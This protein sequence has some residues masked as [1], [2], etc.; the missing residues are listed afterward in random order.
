[1]KDIVFALLAFPLIAVSLIC[2]G[3]RVCLGAP[4]SCLLL[5]QGSVFLLTCRGGQS[6]MRDDYWM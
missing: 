4:G 2:G 5:P 3:T 1:M 6:D